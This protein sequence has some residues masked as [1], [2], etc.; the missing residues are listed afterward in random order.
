MVQLEPNVLLAVKHLAPSGAIVPAEIMVSPKRAILPET[1]IG[2]H[3]CGIHGQVAVD[4]SLPI[5]RSEAGLKTLVLW[6]RLTARNGKVPKRDRFH[7]RNM[8]LPWRAVS[9][10][11]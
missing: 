8:S 4:H 5:K 7:R 1:Y 9:G 2:S 10:S 3:S 11:C 6:G